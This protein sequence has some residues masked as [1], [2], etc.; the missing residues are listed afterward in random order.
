MDREQHCYNLPNPILHISDY[1]YYLIIKNNNGIVRPTVGPNMLSTIFY[2]VLAIEV[3]EVLS[4]SGPPE[5]RTQVF[6]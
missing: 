5:R 6:L 3:S 2:L 1:Y 4:G